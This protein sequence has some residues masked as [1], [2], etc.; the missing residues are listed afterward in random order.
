MR[1][2]LREPLLH[3]LAIGLVLFLSFN[4]IS[5]SRGGADRRIVVNG[6]TVAVL[7]QQYQAAWKRPLTADEL[8]GLIDAHVRDEILFREGL[9]MGL[10]REDPI[11]R[12][13]VQQKLVVMTEESA[14][15]AAPSD[16]ELERYLGTHADRYVRPAVVAFEQVMFNPARRAAALQSDVAAALARLRAGATPDSVGDASL[17]PAST[18]A[19]AVDLIARDYGDAFAASLVALPVGSWSGPVS[20]AYGV[21][22]VRVTGNTPGRPATLGEVR[23]AVERDREKERRQQANDAFYSKARPKYDVVIDVNLADSL[24][25]GARD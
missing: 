22:L 1:K 6:A 23:A 13:R 18:A 17:L 21:H 25:P 10:D 24:K 12:R 19:T 16:A 15:G 3:F 20:S 5:G 4:V 14:A 8:Q 11:I 9:A 7:V 2:F